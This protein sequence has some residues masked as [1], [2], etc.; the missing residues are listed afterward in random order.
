MGVL[1]AT[2]GGAQPKRFG[3][4]YLIPSP[5]DQRLI[6]RIAPAVAEAARKS[7]VATRPIEDLDSYRQRLARF[8]YRSGPAMTPVLDTARRN[9]KRICLAEGEDE[10]VLRAAQTLVDEKIA[11]PVL[12]GRDY[13]INQRI[14]QLGLRLE[15]GRSIEII[16]GQ[17]SHQQQDV[18]RE[19]FDIMKRSG[20]TMA[21]AREKMRSR[22][23]L[24][25]A[26]Y[27]RRG[28]VDGMLCGMRGTYEEHLRYIREVIPC[29]DG[30]TTLAAMN[31]LMLTD[32]QLFICDTYV[33][34]DPSAEEIAEMT[35]LAAEEVRRFGLVPRVALLSHSNFGSSNAPEAVKM[36]KAAAILGETAPGLEVDGEMRADAALLHS[37]LEHVLPDARLTQDA[38]LLVMPSVDAANIAYNLLKV[39]S[40]NNITVGPILLGTAKPAHIL[41]PTASTRRI[42][43][44]AALTAVDAAKVDM[45][46]AG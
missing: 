6:L 36:R 15:S 44:M 43:N 22:P 35:Q 18:E 38:N 45:P 40:S 2:A 13:V 1:Q 21:M 41:E 7:G 9:L 8:V 16:H 11:F 19:Y 31:M 33:N 17:S 10:R 39:T 26:M 32:R 12:V 25:A 46:S 30:V 42:V 24:I 4:D 28:Y 14:R 34:R 37:T 27:L 29:R 5:F 23:T 20:V 3:P